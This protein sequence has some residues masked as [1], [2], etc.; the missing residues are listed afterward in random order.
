MYESMY[1][2]SFL[3]LLDFNVIHIVK[4]FDNFTDVKFHGGAHAVSRSM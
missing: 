2:Q 1:M 3:W 4:L